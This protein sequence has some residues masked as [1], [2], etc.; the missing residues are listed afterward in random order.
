MGAKNLLYFSSFYLVFAPIPHQKTQYYSLHH[1]IV[2]SE[3]PGLVN[4]KINCN[5]MCYTWGFLAN[6]IP[7]GGIT[8]IINL[9]N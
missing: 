8:A 9:Q 1:I 6:N 7:F 3:A 4:K 5:F 2:L